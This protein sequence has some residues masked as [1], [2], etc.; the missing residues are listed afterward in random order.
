MN[1]QNQWL[2]MFRPVLDYIKSESI[3][4]WRKTWKFGAVRNFATKREYN[5]FNKTMLTMFAKDAESD[6]ATLNQI[7]AHQCT[8]DTKQYPGYRIGFVKYPDSKLDGD[9]TTE[10]DPTILGPVRRS[11]VVY[12]I[13]GVRRI[14]DGSFIDYEAPAPEFIKAQELIDKLDIKT[15]VGKP[16]YN[17]LTDVISMPSRGTKAFEDDHSYFSVFFHELGHWAGS[18]TRAGVAEKIKNRD[19]R[20]LEEYGKEELTAEL[21]EMFLRNATGIER[22]EDNENAK[23]Y[24]ANWYNSIKA[25]QEI[26][27]WS[28]GEAQKRANWIL[29]QAGYKKEAVA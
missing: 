28:A 25:D 17:Y 27:Y 20:D 12:P 21:V 18:E 3:L 26:L 4:P 13:G 16:S 23:A 5:G 14:A 29:E 11:Y 22:P 9:E 1:L 24:L 19:P 10:K 7:E 8:I 15:K 6:F 2:S